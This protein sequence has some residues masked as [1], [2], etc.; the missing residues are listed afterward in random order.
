MK[1]RPVINIELTALDKFLEAISLILLIALWA[2]TLTNFS[3]LPDSIPTHYNAMGEVDNT[4][5]KW[6]IFVLAGVAT[7]LYAML[8][9]L[10]RFPHYFNYLAEITEENTYDHY[11]LS[12]RLMRVIKLFLLLLFGAITFETIHIAKG[13]SSIFGFWFMPLT[14]LFMFVPIIVYF[15]KANKIN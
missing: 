12:T 11:K 10:N 13:F 3:D 7:F 6:S 5:S 1:K 9:V 15:F 4:G 2:Y 14:F 8:T